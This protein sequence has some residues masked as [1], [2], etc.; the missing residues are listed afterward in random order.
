MRWGTVRMKC[1]WRRIYSTRSNGYSRSDLIQFNGKRNPG[2]PSFGET[3]WGYFNAPGNVTF[4]TTNIIAF[5]GIV[6]YNTLVDFH[7]AQILEKQILSSQ[8]ELSEQRSDTGAI[9]APAEYVVLSLPKKGRYQQGP[10]RTTE[11]KQKTETE[12]VRQQEEIE[13][14]LTTYSHVE[15]PKSG[16]TKSIQ[17]QLAKASLF[18]LF[19]TFETYQDMTRQKGGNGNIEHGSSSWSLTNPIFNEDQLK[20]LNEISTSSNPATS[21]YKTWRQLSQ[22]IFANIN[23]LYEFKLPNWY[24]F[25]RRLKQLCQTLNTTELATIDEFHELYDTSSD[26]KI[27]KKLM[28]RWLYNHFYLLVKNTENNSIISNESFYREILQDSLRG[29]KEMFLEY[30]SVVLN[31]N[32]PRCGLFFPRVSDYYTVQLSTLMD[33]MQG[34]I[35]L[36]DASHLTQSTRDYNDEI[37]RIVRLLKQNGVAANSGNVRIVLSDEPVQIGEKDRAQYFKII[38]Q[39]KELLSLL[40][41]LK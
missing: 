39:N 3:L 40:K 9:A 15:L 28:R 1:I 37:L 29:D 8:L 20:T 12:Q 31:G 17:A 16:V 6:T 22:P 7:H 21:V 34:Y 33:I 13:S 14:P 25:P 4:V 10:H 32:D 18:H 35:K 19:Y 2:R 38:S 30:S 27:F 11:Q 5:T 23:R 26:N 24:H 41:T 36:R